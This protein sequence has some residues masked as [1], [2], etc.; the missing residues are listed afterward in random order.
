MVRLR[1]ARARAKAREVKAATM[2]RA[3]AHPIRIAILEALS[4]KG[5]YCRDIVEA[6]AVPQSTVS[7]HLKVL[8]EAGL[9]TTMT[10]GPSTRYG[11]STRGIRDLRLALEPFFADWG[12]SATAYERSVLG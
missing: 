8:K 6:I 7:Q 12:R 9:V 3:L 2:A 4:G 5:S 10:F 11:L 1:E